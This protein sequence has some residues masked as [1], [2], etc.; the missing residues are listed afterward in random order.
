MSSLSCKQFGQSLNCKWY[1][2][3]S[4]SKIVSNDDG[5]GLRSF[6]LG[7]TESPLASGPDWV[8]TL[9]SLLLLLQQQQQ[10]GFMKSQSLKKV[11]SWFHILYIK[12]SV[13]NFN[14]S[15]TNE[16]LNFSLKIRGIF[17]NQK[18][19]DSC[20]NLIYSWSTKI[21]NFADNRNS[22]QH[23]LKSNIYLCL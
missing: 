17:K 19:G 5:L 14:N 16:V 2:S 22:W 23:W 21:D 10:K 6:V 3:K 4:Y 9:V 15:M 20:R 8:W 1:S 18:V 11:H 12:I 7:N 13:T